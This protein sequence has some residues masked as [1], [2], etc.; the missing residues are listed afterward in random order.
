MSYTKIINSLNITP[1]YLDLSK[2]SR[3]CV[4]SHS[5]EVVHSVLATMVEHEKMVTPEYEPVMLRD[6][7]GERGIQKYQELKRKPDARIVPVDRRFKFGAIGSS[8]VCW[9]ARIELLLCYLCT[10]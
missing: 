1:A 5:P 3:F 9:C 2:K 7:C 6:I 10:I 4:E 8:V